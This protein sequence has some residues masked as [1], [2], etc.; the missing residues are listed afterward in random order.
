MNPN[1]K[2]LLVQIASLPKLDQNWIIKQL[3]LEQQEQFTQLQGQ[4]LLLKARR[5]RSLAYAP[6]PPIAQ[7]QPLPA[8][9]KALGEQDPLYIAIILEQ[10]L[11]DW[12]QDFLAS[13]EQGPLVQKLLNQNLAHL[14]P[15]SK[16][17]V[18]QHWQ[19]QVPFNLH[20][21]SEHG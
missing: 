11:F 21:G 4:E 13:L 19:N 6:M 10:G 12:A 7:S 1:F 3:S 8:L 5:F 16:L 18:L 9:C 20:L 15:A 14:K 2:K 17:V